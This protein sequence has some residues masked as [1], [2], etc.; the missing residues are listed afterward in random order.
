LCLS[1][2]FD[3]VSETLSDIARSKLKASI[4]FTAVLHTW[5]QQGG[6]H[7]HLHCLAPAGGLAL[8][9]SRWISTSSR[10]F[11]PVKPLRTLFRGKL[12][13]KLEH[14]LRTGQILGDLVPDLA[15]LRRTPKTWNVYAKRPLAGPGHVV[16]YLSRYVHRIAIANSRI[17]HYDGHTVT[18]RYKDRSDGNALKHRTL[19]G[20]DFARRFLQHVLPP[21]FV[22]I[23]HFGLFAARRREDL[24]RS[25]ELLGAQPQPPRE[26]D[27]SWAVAFER[28]F[29]ENPLQCPACKTGVLVVT[30]SLP[31]TRA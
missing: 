16:R 1:L 15:R 2:L 11:L 17:T 20:P 30:R 24:A 31:P 9:G 5:N 14:A 6:F 18:F 21:R 26:K 28:L 13:A 3:A 23:R 8:D 27:A 4:G 10:F 29:G 19:S 22:R 12:L 7:P 25:R